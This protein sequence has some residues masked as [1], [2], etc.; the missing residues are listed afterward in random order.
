VRRFAKGRIRRG[1]LDAAFRAS[2]HM[3]LILS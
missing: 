1:E 2:A 3:F